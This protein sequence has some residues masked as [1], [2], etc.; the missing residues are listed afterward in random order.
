VRRAQARLA[1]LVEGD[2]LRSPRSRR[3]VGGIDGGVNSAGRPIGASS[4][5]NVR[6]RRCGAHDVACA[7]V[8]HRACV[9]PLVERAMRSGPSPRTRAHP[10]PRCPERWP[11]R[12][13]VVLN[14]ADDASEQEGDAPSTHAQVS[15]PGFSRR[16]GTNILR[17][18]APGISRLLR[19]QREF[20]PKRQVPVAQRNFHLR[21]RPARENQRVDR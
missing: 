3:G 1:S 18:L 11:R 7:V 16:S 20:E 8:R 10:P 4:P 14:F 6:A 12:A 21:F 2:A 19:S 15:N 9:S 17:R 5:G 13:V